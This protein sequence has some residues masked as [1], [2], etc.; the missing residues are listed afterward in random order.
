[1]G[2]FSFIFACIMCLVN[3]LCLRHSKYDNETDNNVETK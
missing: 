3:L 1:M 2:N